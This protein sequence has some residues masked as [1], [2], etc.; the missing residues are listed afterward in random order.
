MALVTSIKQALRTKRETGSP[1]VKIAI[2][3]VDATRL[4][5]RPLWMF[6]LDR[7]YRAVVVL[8]WFRPELLHQTTALTWIDRYPEIF[9][10]C[11]DHFVDDPKIKILSF[12]CSSGEEVITLRRYFPCAHIVG[13][14]INRESLA[15]C[16]KQPIDDGMSFVVSDPRSIAKLGPYDLIFCMAVLQRTPCEVD[17]KRMNSLKRIYPFE[18]F[19]QQVRELDSYLRCGGLLVIHHTQ[20]F[21]RDSSVAEKYITLNTNLPPSLHPSKFDR[22]SMRSGDGASDGSIFKKILNKRPA[23][24]V[25]RPAR[26]FLNASIPRK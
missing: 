17:A 9:A 10:A 12:G 2:R 3:A 18:K 26:G 25:L 19:D 20:Y 11:R 4:L 22:N 23:E 13:A 6:A 8:R 14:E 1:A 16:R 21:F 15:M 5:A 24:Q 7:R